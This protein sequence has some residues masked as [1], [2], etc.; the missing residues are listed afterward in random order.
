MMGVSERHAMLK[1]G[2]LCSSDPDLLHDRIGDRAVT[3]IPC[4]VL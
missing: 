1:P 3:L 2:K 4:V